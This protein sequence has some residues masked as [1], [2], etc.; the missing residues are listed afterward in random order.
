MSKNIS[1]LQKKFQAGEI[2]KVKKKL[3]STVIEIC[4]K[5]Y[6]KGGVKFV[7]FGITVAAVSAVWQFNIFF[8]QPLRYMKM[9]PT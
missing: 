9:Y 2:E 8:M 1:V 3:L 4:T 6:R 5:V 7:C